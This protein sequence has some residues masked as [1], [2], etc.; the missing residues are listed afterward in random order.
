MVAGKDSGAGAS[1]SAPRVLRATH[2]D[3]VVDAGAALGE[4]PLWDDARQVLWWIDMMGHQVHRWS[5]G[6]GDEVILDAGTVIGSVALTADGRLAVAVDRDLVVVDPDGGSASLVAV[7][8]GVPGGVLNDS[9]CDPDGNL[10]IG[11]S[12]EEETEPVGCLRVVTPD[13]QVTTVLTGLTVP[14]GIDWSPDE[15]LVYFVDSPARRI[16][17]FPAGRKALGTRA[18][19]AVIETDAMPDGLTVDREGGIWVALWD[20][21]SVRRYLPDGSLDLVVELPAAKV[22]SCAFGGEDFRDLYITTA[23]CDLTAAERAAQ[24]LAGAVF[25]VRTEVAGSPARRFA[26]SGPAA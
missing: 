26:L 15:R 3:V 20:G 14:N 12:T 10:W 13:L 21:W 24:P 11:V 9:G 7:G 16:D 18:T 19:L 22:T 25:R 17:V 6:S 5:P 2:A 8:D 4:G 1:A 23:S